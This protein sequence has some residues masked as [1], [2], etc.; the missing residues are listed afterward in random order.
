M[1]LG[2][3]ARVEVGVGVGV[4]G[5]GVI[6]VYLGSNDLNQETKQ[7]VLLTHYFYAVN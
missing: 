2:L 6:S 1:I 5:G 4:G 3:S 7:I